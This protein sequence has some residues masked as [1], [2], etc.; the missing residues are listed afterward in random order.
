MF[1]GLDKLEFVKEEDG[2][3]MNF[4]DLKKL[5]LVEENKIE[6]AVSPRNVRVF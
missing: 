2:C 3:Q 4:D 5:E 6:A 1:D